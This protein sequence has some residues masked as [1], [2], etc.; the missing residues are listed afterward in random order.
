MI[1]DRDRSYYIGASDTSKVMG[2]W[3]SETFK[4]WFAV[5]LGISQN[6]ITTKAMKVG[7]AFEHKIL[8][9]I[10]GVVKDE[11]IILEDYGL[12]VN[13]DGRLND[14]IIEVKTTNKTP[15]V[16]KAYIQ[17]A[18]VEMFAFKEM[19]GFV[20][21]LSLLFYQVNEEDY[22][23]Y[24]TEID[25]SRLTEIPIAYDDFFISKYLPRLT[26]LHECIVRGVMPEETR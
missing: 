18:Q 10:F 14:K 1:K 9:T 24:F 15:N 17:Q 25:R 8:D 6:N 21:K 16:S 19:H 5:K 3:T 26:Y 4:K 20:P 11:Q 12:R 22:R 7:N 23:N 13:Y 2:N